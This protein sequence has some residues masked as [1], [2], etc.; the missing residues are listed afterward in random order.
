MAQKGHSGPKVLNFLDNIKFMTPNAIVKPNLF[1]ISSKRNRFAFCSVQTELSSKA[2]LLQAVQITL[3]PVAIVNTFN[4]YKKF[5]IIGIVQGGN[6]LKNSKYVVFIINEEHRSKMAALRHFGMA[7]NHVR[8]KI[9]K[10]V[11]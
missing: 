9:I 11:K 6:M 2:P 10:L 4:V 5:E 3:K 7:V 8:Q 1:L